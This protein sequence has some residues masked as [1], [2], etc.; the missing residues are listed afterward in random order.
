MIREEIKKLHKLR[1][2]YKKTK[3]PLQEVIKL[4]M[5]SAYGKMIQKPIV[6]RNVYKQYQTYD[7]DKNTIYPLNNY[8]IKNSSKIKE[9]TQIN[10]NIYLC[11]VAKQ[12]ETFATNTLLGVQVLSMSKRIMNEVMTTAEDLDIKI[13]YQDTDSMHI[14]KS[15]LKDLEINFI[16]DI[17]V[18]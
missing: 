12:I 11:K 18:I 14:E 9:I 1:C 10:R 16:I 13:F 2:E 3:N 7:K 6:D 5:N 17:T 4:I 8:I 15:R